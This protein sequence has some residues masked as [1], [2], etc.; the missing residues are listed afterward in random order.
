MKAVFASDGS[1]NS[2]IAEKENISMLK[3]RQYQY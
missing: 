1:R 3:N 2:T